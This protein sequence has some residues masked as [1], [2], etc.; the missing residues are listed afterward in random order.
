MA[1]RRGIY[2]TH[3]IESV[4]RSLCKVMTMKAVFLDESSVF[5]L[6]YLA[7]GFGSIRHGSR[8]RACVEGG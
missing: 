2:T 3:A 5:K 7:T 6:T 4:H 1:I 8:F